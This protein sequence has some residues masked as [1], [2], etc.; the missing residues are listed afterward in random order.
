MYNTRFSKITITASCLLSIAPMI[1]W[2]GSTKPSCA[3]Q[4]FEN[5]FIASLSERQYKFYKVMKALG[6]FPSEIA[7]LVTEYAGGII[8]NGT[9]GLTSNGAY[10]VCPQFDIPWYQAE[11]GVVLTTKD[12]LMHIDMRGNDWMDGRNHLA[13]PPE[14]RFPTH[15]PCSLLLQGVQTGSLR[16]EFAQRELIFNLLMPSGDVVK[17]FLELSAKRRQSRRQYHCRHLIYK[18]DHA[19]RCDK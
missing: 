7:R 16:L 11:L 12:A 17:R 14:F 2:G 10:R 8:I 4:R 9:I 19:V 13:F 6:I 3:M 18:K 5:T 15:L 1:L